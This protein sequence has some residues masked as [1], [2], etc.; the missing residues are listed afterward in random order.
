MKSRYP[1]AAQAIKKWIADRKFAPG[2]GLPSARLLAEQLGFSLEATQRACNVLISGGVLSRTGYKLFVGTTEPSRPAV[3]GVVH[4]LSYWDGFIHSAERILAERGVKSRAINVTYT[5]NWNMAPILYRAFAEKPAGI[6]IWIPYWMENLAAALKSTRIPMVVCSDFVPLDIPLHVVGTDNFLATQKALRHLLDLGHR[7]IAFV[8]E[9]A[10]ILSLKGV[11]SYQK[12][13]LVMGLKK[14]ATSV[15]KVDYISENRDTLIEMRKRQPEV[16][17]LIVY[18]SNSSVVA[19]IFQVPGDLSIICIY[20]SPQTTVAFSDGDD[21][22]IQSACSNLIVQIQTI[23]SGR[24]PRPPHHLLFAPALIDRGSTRALTRQESNSHAPVENVGDR[25]ASPWES[26][27]KVYPLLIESGA[28][29]W[30]Q[31]DLATLVNHSMTREHGWLGGEPLLHFSPG[32]RSIHGVPFQ[33]IDENRN[34]GRAVVTFRSSRAHTAGKKQLPDAVLLP[35]DARVKA[36]YFLHGCGFARTTQFAEYIMH[37]K[38]GKTS[39]VPIV[40][41]GL[42]PLPADR[43][44]SGL[45]PNIQDWWSRSEPRDFPHAMHATVFNPGDPMGYERHLYT[46]EWINPHPGNEISRIEARIDP[47]AGPTLALIAV[48]ALMA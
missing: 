11:D 28:H 43:L 5:N 46:L 36:L 21:S 15:W 4:I 47:N 10:H 18:G 22:L 35:V 40:T 34:N 19:K 32:L 37:F 26:W 3:D 7:E 6:L 8:C 31:L 48:T 24:P 27:R 45:K 9:T 2:T 20:K 41:L 1:E 16:T 44:P 13:C 33:V 25:P 12:A 14:S 42:S 38:N 17:A 29:N 39:T 23:E 30:L